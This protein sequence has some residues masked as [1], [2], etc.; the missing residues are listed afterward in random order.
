MKQ[1]EIPDSKTFKK[2]AD[3]KPES[4]TGEPK[5]FTAFLCCHGNFDNII[6]SHLGNNIK[7]ITSG[8]EDLSDKGVPVISN[9]ND[10]FERLFGKSYCEGSKIHYIWEHPELIEGDYVAICHYRRIFRLFFDNNLED[11]KRKLTAIIGDGDGVVVSNRAT[12]CHFGWNR[13]MWVETVRETFYRDHGPDYYDKMLEVIKEYYPSFYENALIASDDPYM[14]FFN[15][16]IMH[17]EMFK[18][19]CIFV[20]DFFDKLNKKLSIYCD[21][22]VSIYVRGQVDSGNMPCPNEQKFYWQKRMHGFIMEFI[23]NLFVISNFSPDK[24]YTDRIDI[25][26]PEKKVRRRET[27]VEV[28]KPKRPKPDT[29]KAKKER[30]N[31]LILTRYISNR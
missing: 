20:F 29:R 28:K 22:D 15:V 25:P 12:F 23:T 2:V 13:K 24:I 17:K 21:D 27:K 3:V 30:Y 10:Y 8:E 7:L 6:P 16:T 18:K 26:V 1:K 14:F 31:K 9:H 11:V 5:N 19:Y 4:C